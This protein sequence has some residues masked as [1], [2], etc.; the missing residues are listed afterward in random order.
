[1][2]AE[3]GD[4]VKILIP[5]KGSTKRI[6]TKVVDII[7]TEVSGVE[8]YDCASGHLVCERDLGIDDVLLASEVE[9]G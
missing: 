3:R 9:I 2:K 4:Y 6:T 5:F 8:Y 1:M 7:T